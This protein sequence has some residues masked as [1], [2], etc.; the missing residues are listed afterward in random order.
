MKAKVKRKRQNV[1]YNM[2]CRLICNSNLGEQT[3]AIKPKIRCR[4]QNYEFL[5]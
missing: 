3:A 5:H 1:Q 4:F 2:I